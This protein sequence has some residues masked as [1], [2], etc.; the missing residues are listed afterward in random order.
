MRNFRSSARRVSEAFGRRVPVLYRSSRLAALLAA[1]IGIVAI[2]AGG[3]QLEDVLEAQAAANAAAAQAQQR[4]NELTE[5]TQEAA[6][7]YAQVLA[8][9]KSFEQ[10]NK[11]LS[12]Q[13]EAQEAE[14]A[15]IKR[16]LEEI[17]KTARKIK[18]LLEDMVQSL[19]RFVALDLP[20]LIEERTQRV[21]D[22]KHLLTRVDVS[23]SEKYRQILEAYLI[24]LEYGH[25]LG[26]YKGTLGHGEDARAVQFVRVGR[27]ALMYQTLNGEETGYWNAEQ[28]K[29]VVAND[30]AEEFEAALKMAHERGAPVLLTVPV[31]VPE[32]VQS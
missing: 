29:W 24:E 17:E 8:E 20:F 13:I 14:I 10:Y 2:P 27:V 3:A 30:Y 4:I 23:I 28:N 1:V 12:E 21:Q 5:R 15:S 32:E 6:A 16:Q 11:K 7:R 22:L 31:P 9:A 26:A 25:T 19:A 18:P